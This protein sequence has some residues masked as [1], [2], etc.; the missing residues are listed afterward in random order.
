VTSVVV[1]ILFKSNGNI[2]LD[3]VFALR[4]ISSL[5]SISEQ[6]FSVLL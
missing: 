5:S 4:F 6:S 3:L 2:I 1:W